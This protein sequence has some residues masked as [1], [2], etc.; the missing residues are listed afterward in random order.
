M[1]VKM[2]LKK[3]LLYLLK[4]KNWSLGTKEI[5]RLR[6]LLYLLLIPIWSLAPHGSPSM[7]GMVLRPLGHHKL[8]VQWCDPD[9]P[10]PSIHPVPLLELNHWAQPVNLWEAPQPSDHHLGS[11]WY[12]YPKNELITITIV[13]SHY[14]LTIVNCYLP[15]LYFS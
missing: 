13:T 6:R 5:T 11:P 15:L 3:K 4:L 10:K 9:I 14:S 2:T 8:W 7:E 1:L 12:S